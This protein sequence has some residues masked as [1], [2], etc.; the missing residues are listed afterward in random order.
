MRLKD[1]LNKKHLGIPFNYDEGQKINIKRKNKITSI[2]YRPYSKKNLGQFKEKVIEKSKTNYPILNK[3]NSNFQIGRRKTTHIQIDS[4]KMAT[5]NNNH[6]KE[7]IQI[8]C[9]NYK[10]EDLNK[11]NSQKE[12]E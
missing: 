2:N 5:Q 4:N 6:N 8:N 11:N 7:N 12:I 10:I 3:T 9:Y 1:H